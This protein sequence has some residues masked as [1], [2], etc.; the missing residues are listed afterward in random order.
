VGRRD[1]G[2]QRIEIR[3]SEDGPPLTAWQ[4]IARGGLLPAIH[5]LV[6]GRHRHRGLLVVG[7]DHAAT[8]REYAQRGSQDAAHRHGAPAGS[9]FVIRTRAPLVSESAGETIT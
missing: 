5:L 7:T 6:R 8:K 3:I 4:V 9:T 1:L 2:L